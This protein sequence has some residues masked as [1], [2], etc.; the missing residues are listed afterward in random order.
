MA[1]GE[2]VNSMVMVDKLTTRIA[3]NSGASVNMIPMAIKPTSRTTLATREGH[4][5]DNSAMVKLLKSM[6]RN[7]S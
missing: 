4:L 5:A 3:I 1:G 7:I 2:S 6:V